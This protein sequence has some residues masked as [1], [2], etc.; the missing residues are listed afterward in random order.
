MTWSLLLILALVIFLLRYFFLEP[1]IPVKLPSVIRQALGYS[2]PCLLTAIC[3]PIVLLEKGEF[4]GILD[5]PYLWGTLLCV[6][7]AL[8]IRNTLM[9]VLL[10]LVGFYLLNGLL[11]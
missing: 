2:A 4:K 8:K 5:N 11:N 3:A 7:L 6:G 9:V 1:A 10:T